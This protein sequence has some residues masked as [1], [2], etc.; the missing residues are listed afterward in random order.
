M[1]HLPPTTPPPP[2]VRFPGVPPLLGASFIQAG[3]RYVRYAFD[4]RGRASRSEYWWAMLE[5]TIIEVV[6]VFCMAYWDM[7]PIGFIL[8]TV[9]T[10]I[11]TISVRVRRL[12]DGGFSG[13]WILLEFIF[14]F[15]SIALL[16]LL[17]MPSK[18]PVG[19]YPQQVGAP[20]AQPA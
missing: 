12:H 3:K 10:I 11:P 9:L 6:I 13:W 7:H 19:F 4:F 16:A 18:E 1:S 15:G 2:S 8:F 20:G 5:L 14:F 17:C